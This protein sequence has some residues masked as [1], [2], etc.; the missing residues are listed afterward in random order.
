M[1]LAEALRVLSAADQE[2]P[3]SPVTLV[4]GS[5]AEPLSVFLAAQLQVRT[6]GRRVLVKTGSFG[7][8]AGNLER[9][10]SAGQEPGV[11]LLEW[12]DLDPRLGMRQAGN[13]G[14]GITADVL[15]TA[16][17]RLHHLARAL[18]THAAGP[19]LAIVPPTLPLPP[20]LP[21]PRWR[22]DALEIGLQELSARFLARV[23]NLPRVSVLRTERLQCP[24]RERLDLK[25]W[26]Q[27]GF[28]YRLA[29]ACELAEQVAIM[30][31]PH[32]RAKGIITD[33]DDTLWA[34]ILGEAGVGGVH[35]DLDHHAAIHGI[36][37]QFLQSLADD[38]VLVAI[39]SKNDGSLV[40][41]ALER[42]DMLLRRESVFPVE[43]HWQPK[44]TSAARI[45]QAWNVA[46]DSVLFV[47]DCPLEVESMQAAFP[48]M[49][50]RLFPVGDPDGFWRFLGD[51]ADLCG[52]AERTEEDSLRL[53]S[54][55]VPRTGEFA[56]ASPEEV[57]RSCEGALVLAPVGMPPDPRAL[58]LVNKTNQFNLNGARYTETDWLEYLRRPG[59]IAW[60]ASYQDK[61]GRLGKISVLAGRRQ[62]GVLY[63]D[64]WVMSCRA[65]SRRIEH[66]MLQYLFTGEQI[67]KIVLGFRATGR[68]APFRELVERVT[69]APPAAGIAITP[70]DLASE[71][72]AL[73]LSVT[74]GQ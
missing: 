45:L 5:T 20:V 12:A 7:D 35:W 11:V 72:P 52:K 15:R 57:L 18:E 10:L 3:V 9:F 21:V 34:G 69:G 29:F 59:A 48:S 60:I 62:A 53:E 16:E 63:V 27:A 41:E 19:I 26:W 55:R 54:L 33:L 61:F 42:P 49:D 14:R 30:L 50:C 32:R 36:Y 1:K 37:Q 2:A 71:G 68:N 67:R 24:S 6:S 56:A 66:S 46:P 51:L 47:D 23:S 22:M 70:A 64:V 25:Y 8:L 17:A 4:S 43:A 39:A 13:W 28:P 31:A 40:A 73:Y 38:G 74:A 65:F 44:A 58:E